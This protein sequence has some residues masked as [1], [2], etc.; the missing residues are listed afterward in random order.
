MSVEMQSAE[1]C[2]EHGELR[3]DPAI[4]CGHVRDEYQPI[5][6]DEAGVEVQGILAFS[7]VAVDQLPIPIEHVDL[8]HDVCHDVEIALHV[9]LHAIGKIERHRSGQM[10]LF[11]ESRAIRE[12]L[13]LAGI[14]I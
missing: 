9:K 12:K 1:R 4:G 14:A 6:E 8:V 5:L 7:A 11:V 2:Y 10:Q 3:I 13:D